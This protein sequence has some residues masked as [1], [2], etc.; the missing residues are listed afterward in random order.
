[1]YFAVV[2]FFT[3]QKLLN[4][5]DSSKEQ[6]N[7]QVDYEKKY[8]KFEHLTQPRFYKFN[9]T[10]DIMPEERSMTAKVEAWAKNKS[11]APIQELHFT[12]PQLSDSIKISISGAKLKLKDS[13]L[14]YR[15]YTLEKPLIAK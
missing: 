12:M 14:N 5:Y 3:T 9:Y 6:E 7:K 2:L 8:K 11:N 15:I 1:M 4:T 13:R 10:I